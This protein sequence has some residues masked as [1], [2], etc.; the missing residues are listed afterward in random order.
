MLNGVRG[1]MR[2]SCGLTGLAGLGRVGLAR[3]H[4]A[5]RK[6]KG[7]DGGEGEG[8]V[9]VVTS[10]KGGVGKTTTSASM[11]YR[12]AELGHKTVA[13]DFD[14]G[15]RNLDLHLGME[16]RVVFDFVNVLQGEAELRQALIKDRRNDNLYVLAASQTRD[17]TAL[18]LEG[19][20]KVINQLKQ[21]FDYVLCDSP[22]GIESGAHHAMYFADEAIVCTNPELSSV[23]D[24]DKMIGLLASKSKRAADGREPIDAYLLITRYEPERVADANMLSV[25]DISEMLGIPLLGVIPNSEAVLTSTNLGQPVV[26]QDPNEVDCSGAFRD[27]VDRFLGKDIPLRFLEPKKKGFLSKLFS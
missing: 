3:V 10:G 24:S 18:T 15:L 5:A 13:I 12:L 1:A 4:A 7:G 25:S 9:V 23:R 17:K 19:V 8:R 20:E 11:A 27:F 22:A 14:I 16:R 21:Q 2:S 6:V 26:M